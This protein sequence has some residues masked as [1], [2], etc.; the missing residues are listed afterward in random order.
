MLGSVTREKVTGTTMKAKFDLGKITVKEEAAFALALS[1]QEAAF[2]LDKHA[3]GDCGD[4]DPEPAGDQAERAQWKRHDFGR[5]RLLADSIAGGS[6]SLV[7]I[8]LLAAE[9]GGAVI[10]V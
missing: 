1:G 8:G 9:D 10:L 6:A 5:R 3:S 2:F 7:R 4:D